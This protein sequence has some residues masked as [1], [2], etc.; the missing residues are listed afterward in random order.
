V[1]IRHATEA[2]LDVMRRLWDESTAETTYT[3]YRGSPFEAALVT[4]HVALLAEEAGEAVGAVYANFATPHYGFVFGLYTR[5]DA[6]RRGV[7]LA[8]M[9]AI[10]VA[11]R[12]EGRRYIVLSVDT[13]NHAARA[14]YDRL[15][16]V[17]AARVLRVDVETLLD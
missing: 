5:P 15:G 6:R 7:A 14:L 16:F 12:D 9:R 11:V 13:P 17:D 4:D 2:D 10:A 1:K 8:L 3:P